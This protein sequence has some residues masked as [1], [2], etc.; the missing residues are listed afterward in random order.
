MYA[1]TLL[2]LERGHLLRLGVWAALSVLIGAL[3]LGLMYWR[4]AI[5]PFVRH[6][7]IQLLSWGLIDAAIVGWSWSDLAYRD[8]AHA[9]QMQKFLWLNVGLDA[10]YVGVGITLALA[11][12]LI[13]KRPGVLGA[14]VGVVVQGFALFVLDLRLLTIIDGARL[15]LVASPVYPW[16]FG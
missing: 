3:I 12:W 1:D 6:F 14:G 2:D 10:G 5:A 4:K 16:L 11:G 8:Y 13:G 7:A 15:A 9:M